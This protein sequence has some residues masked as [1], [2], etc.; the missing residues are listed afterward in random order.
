M[1]T[2]AL[3]Q[4][5][6]LVFLV[7]CIT[8]TCLPFSGPVR[9]A[10]NSACNYSNYSFQFVAAGAEQGYPLVK[11][12]KDATFP[13]LLKST[14]GESSPSQVDPQSADVRSYY[15][16]SG[17]TYGDVNKVRLNKNKLKTI[18]DLLETIPRYEQGKTLSSPWIQVSSGQ[19]CKLSI[20]VLWNNRQFIA[21]QAI[22][23]QV[24]S[25]P[26]GIVTSERDPTAYYLPHEYNRLVILLEE[27]E[28]MFPGETVAK[29][30]SPELRNQQERVISV[31]KNRFP[32][33]VIWWFSLIDTNMYWTDSGVFVDMLFQNDKKLADHVAKMQTV[34][35]PA[36]VSR[37][38]SEK[39]ETEVIDSILD[40][41]GLIDL[42]SYR[43]RM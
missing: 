43:I 32:P 22:L 31:I 7:C 27:F 25:V 14:F 34:L 5:S 26:A 23:N 16:L 39:R 3:V 29:E 18:V 28:T 15:V 40:V 13:S 37:F 20:A 21:D 33:E 10:T 30:S 1:R 36:L 12:F 8:T 42:D 17:Y 24:G 9:A 4:I 38:F 41:G 35:L 2:K 11:R 6:Y 19:G